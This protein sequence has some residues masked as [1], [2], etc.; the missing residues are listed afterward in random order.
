[1]IILWPF[2]TFR[3]VLPLVPFILGYLATGVQVLATAAGRIGGRVWLTSEAAVRIF[4]LVLI[5]LNV[6]DHV[7]Y[8]AVAYG[9]TDGAPWKQ[10]AANIDRMLDWIA[11][12]APPDAVVA[13]DNPALVYLRTGHHTIAANSFDDRWSRWTRLNVRYLM[14]LGDSELLDDPRAT[15]RYKLPDEDLWTFEISPSNR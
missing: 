12:N 3:F 2:W 1:M 15:L 11:H 10:H 6:L 7:Q 9:N 5:G 8:V 4:F 14:S 13:A